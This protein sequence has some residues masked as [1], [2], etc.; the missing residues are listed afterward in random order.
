M[1]L[2]FILNL[3]ICLLRVNIFNEK[4]SFKKLKTIMTT[5]IVLKIYFQ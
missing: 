4:I 2:D 3:Y 1:E 5:E